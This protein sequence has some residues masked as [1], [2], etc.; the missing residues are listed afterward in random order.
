MSSGRKQSV[1]RHIENE[2]IHNGKAVLVDYATYIAG[3]KEGL[4]FPDPP[5]H[6]TARKKSSEPNYEH[7][8]RE[9][10]CREMARAF[11]R[12][13]IEKAITGNDALDA[14]KSKILRDILPKLIEDIA[15]LVKKEK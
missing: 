6:Y 13:Y 10:L 11:V 8:V 1:I 14:L 9:E 15:S 12:K 3:V 4:Y 7:I 5:P 2:N